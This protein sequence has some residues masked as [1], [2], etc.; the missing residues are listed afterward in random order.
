MMTDRVYCS[1]C[2]D[3]FYN[4][5]NALGIK[6]CW[7]LEGAKVVSKYRIGWWT[8]C[9]RKE[10]F[11]KVTTLS[12]HMESGRVAFFEALPVHLRGSGADDSGR[13]RRWLG[14]YFRFMCFEEV[15]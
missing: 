10:N 2:D 15:K 14:K 12:C 9:D 11:T 7:N 1:G 13:V 4:G 5:N 3:D 6:E 8:P